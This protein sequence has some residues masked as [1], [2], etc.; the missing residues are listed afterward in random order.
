WRDYAGSSDSSKFVALDQINKSNVSRLKV[1][2][3]YPTG[4]G[5]YLFN[6]IIVDNVMYVL[7]ANSSLIALDATTGNEI[8]VHEN[9]RGIATRGINYW[10]SKDRK[11]R[12]LIF[13]INSFL[14]EIDARTG[15]SILSF[16]KNGLVDLREGLG[17]DPKTIARIQSNTPGR[18]FE[19]L[20]MLGSATGENY[21][22]S[23]GHIRP[24]DVVTGKLAWIFHTIPQPGEFGYD[25]WPKDAWKYAG[26]TNTW[27]EIT[28]DEKRGIAYFPTGSSTY[29][30]YGGDRTGANLFAN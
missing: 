9:L 19:N 8:W 21:M 18:V 13:Q 22:A 25:T 15:K 16:G 24:W 20:I 5:S 7:S 10:E 29:D 23:P 11:D 2:W 30:I 4:N 27:G 12:R 14:Q 26:G 17:R 1:A 28:L 6:P 3:T